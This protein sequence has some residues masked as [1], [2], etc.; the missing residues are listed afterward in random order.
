MKSSSLLKVNPEITLETFPISPLLINSLIICVLEE[1]TH[2]V[3][4][5]NYLLF[6]L[7]ISNNSYNYLVSTDPHNGFSTK[8]FLPLSKT[9]LAHSNFIPVGKGIYTESIDLSANN[10]S[11]V[12]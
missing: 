12:P 6:F 5:I 8:A 11:Y 4:S 1:C 10:S 2:I 7:A 9:F 3:Q